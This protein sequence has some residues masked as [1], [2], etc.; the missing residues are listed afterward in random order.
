VLTDLLAWRDTETPRPEIAYW[1]TAHG[2]EVDFVV[3][4]K[5]KLLVIEVESGGEPAPR[6]AAHVLSFLHQ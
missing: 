2:E 6:D 3:D 4:R 1:R 5:R